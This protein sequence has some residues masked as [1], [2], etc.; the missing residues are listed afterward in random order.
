VCI[1]ENGNETIPSYG[2]DIYEGAGDYSD[3]RSLQAKCVSD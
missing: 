1:E 3:T 2:Q